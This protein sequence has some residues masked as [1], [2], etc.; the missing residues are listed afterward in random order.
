MKL[1]LAEEKKEANLITN[2]REINT[3]KIRVGNAEWMDP[4]E[5]MI[6]AKLNLTGTWTMH[7]LIY[8]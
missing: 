4:L 7:K 2:R 1:N 3:A 8:P 5:A 6:D